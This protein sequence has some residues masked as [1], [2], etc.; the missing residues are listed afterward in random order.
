MSG[1]EEE[2]GALMSM[3]MGTRSGL[4]FRRGQGAG[5][6][7]RA[8]FSRL[9]AGEIDKSDNSVRG[10]WRPVGEDTRKRKSAAQTSSQ[11]TKEANCERNFE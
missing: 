3:E 4:A 2:R 1:D 10:G 5:R 6:D 8:A 7:G 11:Q 9:V